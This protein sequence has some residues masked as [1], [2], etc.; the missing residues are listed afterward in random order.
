MAQ[1]FGY[2]IDRLADAPMWAKEDTQLR[3]EAILRTGGGLPPKT[4]RDVKKLGTA[5]DKTS[6][7]FDR[8]NEGVETL[9]DGA[10]NIAGSFLD[11]SGRIDSLNPV[12]D[13]LANLLQEGVKGFG[14][15][16]PIIGDGLGQLGALGI[17]IGST[18]TQAIATELD[19]VASAF[20]GIASR[21]ATLNGN[22]GDI[23][24]AS[25]QAGFG[26]EMLGKVLDNNTSV[27]MAFGDSSKGAERVLANLAALRQ[28]ELYMPLQ[29]LGFTVEGLADVAGQYYETLVR[30][31]RLEMLQEGNERE[32]ARLTGEYA[33]NLALIS[34]LTGRNVDEIQQEIRQRQEE[35][36]I[37]VSN[38]KIAQRS[39]DEVLRVVEAASSLFNDPQ[40]NN[41]IRMTLTDIGMASVP[42]E[43]VFSQFPQAREALR[44]F[45][46]GLKDGTITEQQAKALLDEIILAF[47]TEGAQGI[48][49]A[50]FS[51]YA[52]SEFIQAINTSAAA[53]VDFSNSTD[54]NLTTADTAIQD[55]LN[56]SENNIKEIITLEEETRRRALEFQQVLGQNVSELSTQLVEAYGRINDIMMAFVD[57]DVDA[58]DVIKQ[59]AEDL[60]NAVYEAV[61]SKIDTAYQ[62]IDNAIIEMT[63]GQDGFVAE[64]RETVQ[65]IDRY[66]GGLI[67]ATM[68]MTPEGGEF[69]D[70]FKNEGGD[71]GYFENLIGAIQG[72]NQG[73]AGVQNF[74]EGTLARLHGEEAVI[75]APRGDIPVDLGN[76]IKNLLAQN[77]VNSV[78]SKQV[79][80]KFDEMIGVLKTIAD[81]TYAGNSMFGK[82]IRRLGSQMSA[83]LYR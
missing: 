6:K 47:K 3:I 40:L 56:S 62:T 37:I 12:V 51:P 29:Q 28:D 32:V 8:F 80:A 79:V 76:D 82:E 33:K 26:I 74:G 22:L 1:T 50:E 54:K 5:S 18:V 66:L 41:A 46:A 35:G 67:R 53:I 25:A 10:A 31:G 16:F 77:G 9:V 44:E 72:Y 59:Q 75:P 19:E 70:A 17:Q 21:G 30:T 20:R 34:R 38:R 43:A 64:G 81:G 42:F 36:F 78:Q 73:T 45:Q 23:I 58:V 61:G 11:T 27:L 52:S 39:G 83:D 55:L 15:L 60:A 13:T 4:E 68:G 69:V 49:V 63:G 71:V 48:N 2:D 24:T 7:S 14:N 65:G 57:P